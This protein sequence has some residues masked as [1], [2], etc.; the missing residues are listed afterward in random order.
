MPIVIKEIHVRTTIEKSIKQELVSHETIQ[1][2]KYDILKEMQMNKV[3][4]QPKRK[5]R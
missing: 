2:I 1:R 5:E 3:V 4:A